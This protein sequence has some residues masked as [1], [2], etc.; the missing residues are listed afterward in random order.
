MEIFFAAFIDCG[1]IVIH[2]EQWWLDVLRPE[3]RFGEV[4]V[5]MS[6]FTGTVQI[7]EKKNH[8]RS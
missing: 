3:E 2:I 5:E 4:I 7:T 6:S 1:S 8:H